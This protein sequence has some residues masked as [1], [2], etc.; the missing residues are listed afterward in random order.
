MLSKS[1]V[2]ICACLFLLGCDAQHATLQSS[3]LAKTELLADEYD[4]SVRF[5]VSGDSQTQASAK[6]QGLSSVFQTWA[7][8]GYAEGLKLT[9]K[10]MQPIYSY[11]SNGQRQ[12]KGY[13]ASEA[14][15]LARLS[16]S[17]YETVMAKLPSFK[18][19]HFNMLRVYAGEH[20]VEKANKALL[21]EAFE[22]A[23]GKA[24]YMAEISNICDVRALEVKEFSQPMARPM[25]MARESMS[26]M[27]V[28]SDAKQALQARIEVVWQGQPCS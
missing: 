14:F 15:V 23:K 22:E 27:K 24:L 25:M 18:P 10:N 20:A 12:L 5:K 28:N 26:A 17:Q 19:E 2:A 11:P 8:Q 7:Q 21:N 1:L 3:G 16:K 9:A 4:V 13:E 6:L